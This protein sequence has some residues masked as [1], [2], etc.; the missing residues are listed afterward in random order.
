MCDENGYELRMRMR[1][2][3]RDE[4]DEELDLRFTITKRGGGGVRQ[5]TAD[6]MQCID[7]IRWHL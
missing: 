7:G 1:D 4:G 2:D 3:M 5:Q 6:S